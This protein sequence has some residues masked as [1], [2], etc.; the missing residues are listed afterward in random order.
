MSSCLSMFGQPPISIVHPYPFTPIQHASKH[1]SKHASNMRKLPSV[2]NQNQ[3]IGNRALIAAFICAFFLF[4]VHLML[5]ACAFSFF[6]SVF[7]FFEPNPSLQSTRKLLLTL[8][9]SWLRLSFSLSFS[10][11]HS[12]LIRLTSFHCCRHKNPQTLILTRSTP[13]SQAK[14][15]QAKQEKGKPR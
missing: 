5:R 7:V 8:F 13:P 14:S 12:L 6:F 11:F 10:L 15:S 4:F 9:S 1:A 2:S 3:R